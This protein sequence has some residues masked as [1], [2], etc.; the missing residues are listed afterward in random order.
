MSALFADPPFVAILRG[1]TPPE[2]EAVALVLRGAGFL[3]I[4]T[5]LNSP[6]ALRSIGLMRKA[7]GP[8]ARIGAGTVLSAAEVES[9]AAAGAD[10]IVSPN[11]DSAVIAATKARGLYSMPGFFTASEA[12][13]ALGAGADALKLFPA[14][15]AGPAYVKSLKA[16]LPPEAPVLAVGGIDETR[17]QAYMDAGAAGFGLGGAV[18]RPGMAAA[19]VGAR[20]EAFMHAYREIRR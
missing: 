16:V 11:T 12:F 10:F 19:D 14:D 1:I 4:E 18:Y 13:A 3:W 5:P 8:D 15:A 20:A 2:A 6:D 9:S 17:L 7:L